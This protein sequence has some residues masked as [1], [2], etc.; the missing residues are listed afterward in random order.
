MKRQFFYPARV[1]DQV[2]WLSNFASKVGA[3]ATALG[4]N[5]T[6]IIADT[7]WLLYVLG[8]WLENVRTYGTGATQY[9]YILQNG[10][11]G[12]STFPTPAFVNTTPPV[13]VVPVGAGILSRLFKFVQDIKDAPLY[14]TVIGEDLGIIG[15]PVTNGQPCPV[16]TLE[17]AGGE[18][19][20]H[21]E[22]SF[23][24]FTHQGVTIDSRRGA[25]ENF[26]FL[27]ND[28]SRPFVDERPLL[29]PGV[30]EVR[31]YRLRFWDKGVANGEWSESASIT[32]GPV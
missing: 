10:L 27:A 1:G 12:G 15:A 26:S 22:V 7:K 32:V 17:L 3:H 4:L 19:C 5:A 9:T 29:V 18:T 2:I 23:Q 8:S 30:P 21:V 20:D 11:T 24:K 14:T 25:E 13:G 16:F 6:G 28:T 31:E